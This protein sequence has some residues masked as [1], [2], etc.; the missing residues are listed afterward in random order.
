MAAQAAQAAQ[1]KERTEFL[2]HKAVAYQHE[3]AALEVAEGV[4]KEY[5]K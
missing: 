1:R 5:G 4:D 3:A 2:L